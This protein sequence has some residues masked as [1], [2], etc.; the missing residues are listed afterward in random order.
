M[1][2]RRWVQRV[3]LRSAFPCA[4]FKE[5][6]IN[7]DEETAPRRPAQPP[8]AHAPDHAVSTACLLYESR[9]RLHSFL[10]V[11]CSAFQK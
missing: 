6:V 4:S 11:A 7:G 10:K 2:R 8:I 5:I 9:A 1:V 3:R